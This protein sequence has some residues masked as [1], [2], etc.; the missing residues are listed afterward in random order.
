M[1]LMISAQKLLAWGKTP[2]GA[3][4]MTDDRLDA[5]CKFL[6]QVDRMY[7]DIHRHD[8]NTSD[9]KDYL[10]DTLAKLRS[11]HLDDAIIV[12]FLSDVHEVCALF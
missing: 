6:D 11:F 7:N 4:M 3:A 1:Q 5:T 9:I 8:G 12:G 10:N 2:G